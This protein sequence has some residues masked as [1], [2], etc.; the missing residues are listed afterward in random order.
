MLPFYAF[1]ILVLEWAQ[2]SWQLGRRGHLLFGI[3]E[4]DGYHSI[5]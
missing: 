3:R 2:Y 4:R 5:G 1:I